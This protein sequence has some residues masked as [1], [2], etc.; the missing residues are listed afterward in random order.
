MILVKY[1]I[2][3][4]RKFEINS[5]FDYIDMKFDKNVKLLAL[6]IYN[7]QTL[8]TARLYPARSSK[9]DFLEL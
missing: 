3:E 9:K 2:P 1:V 4:Y 7:V 5:V 8:G 6:V